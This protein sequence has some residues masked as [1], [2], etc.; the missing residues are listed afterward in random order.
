MA[1]LK[2]EKLEVRID[3]AKVMFRNF[4]GAP[5][6]YNQ[7]GN[8]NFCVFLPDDLAR[9]MES[10]GWN[11]RWL[12]SREDEPPQAMVAVKVNYGNYPPSIFIV[13]N[14]KASKLSEEN[15]KE[16]DTAELEQ[17]DL[18]IRGYSW[19]VKGE[20]GIKAYLKEGY[21]VLATND[22]AKKYLQPTDPLSNN[23]ND[24]EGLIIN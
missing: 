24:Y 10:K 3:N 18:I 17:V 2:K 4:S 9:D 8:R 7:A 22:L 20:T 1:D 21:F 13:S 16:L 14:G 5:G 23:A 11:I 19:E 12:K 6:T 15:V